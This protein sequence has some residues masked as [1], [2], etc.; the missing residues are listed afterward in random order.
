MIASNTNL[1]V[2]LD[3]VEFNVNGQWDRRQQRRLFRQRFGECR[4]GGESVK[5]KGCGYHGPD[6]YPRSIQKTD[7]YRIDVF[8]E[9]ARFAA[10][11]FIFAV[12]LQEHSEGG[13]WLQ[14]ATDYAK[15]LGLQW[16][17]E[18]PSRLDLKT[19]VALPFNEFAGRID[20]G[21]IV[22]R[23]QRNRKAENPQS[24]YFGQ[25][26]GLQIRLY[27]KRPGVTRVE[28]EFGRDWLFRKR[29]DAWADV[30][31]PELWREATH[32]FRITE[33]KPDGKHYD[34][35]KLW[36]P[37]IAIQQAVCEST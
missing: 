25:K 21:L 22:C 23:A 6:F 15:R 35:C 19:D 36:P 16:E 12:L 10:R 18:Q 4:L 28:F 5:V 11:V 31:P 32:W 27:A 34:R 24:R 2:E 33:T 30:R 26:G 14:R 13:E 8:N 17:S 1:S 9:T 7:A 20:N 29:I 3:R 37:W